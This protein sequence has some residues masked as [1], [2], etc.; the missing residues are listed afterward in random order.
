MIFQV[1]VLIVLLAF[2]LNLIL[3][4]IA[5]KRP[6]KSAGLPDPAPFVSILVPAR[7]EEANIGRCVDSLLAQDYPAFEVIVLD[8]NSTDNTAAVI[9]E[10]QQRD[11]RLR[12]ING[13]PL[14][15]GWAG[16]PFACHQ[17]AS[18][19]V[20]SWL[21]FID[22]DTVHQ[23]F[24]LRGVMEMSVRGRL[25]LLSGLPRQLTSGFSQRIVMPLMYFIIL[26]WF[27]IWFLNKTGKPWPTM[28]IG[29]FMLFPKEAYW[30]VGGHAAVKTRIIEDVWFGVEIKKSGGRFVAADLST[31]MSTDMYQSVETM[32]EGWGKWIYSVMS[33]SPIALGAAFAA[34]YLFFLAP[35]FWLVHSFVLDSGP[36]DWKYVVLAQVIVLLLMRW[37]VD[38]RFKEPAGSFIF[39]PLGIIFLVLVA[40]YSAG[41]RAVGAGVAWKGRVYD[42]RSRIE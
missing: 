29:Q 3:N 22:A 27:P 35:Y 25:S 13:K 38:H 40:I 12:L 21:L 41:R 11:P 37:A 36:S 33:L 4:L 8:D 14:P 32:S 23:S 39:H 24:M 16:K 34:V 17:L 7:N 10:I 9:A 15:P 6:S 42:G 31:V 30:K 19:A 28:A 18:E 1:L 26:S 5:L 20:G 2:A